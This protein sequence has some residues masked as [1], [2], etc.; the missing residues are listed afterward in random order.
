MDELIND[1]INFILNK[2][3]NDYKS[4]FQLLSI[5]FKRIKDNPNNKESY[6]IKISNSIFKEKTEKI[7]EI[8]SLIEL[9]GYC[10]S[11][12]DKNIYI[13]EKDCIENVNIANTILMNILSKSNP[14]NNPNPSFTNNN[15][16]NNYSNNLTSGEKVIIYQYDLTMGL[17]SSFGSALIGK[18]IEGVWHTAVVCFGKEYFYG[19]GIQVGTPKQTPYGKPV[20]ELD[21]GYTNKT[22]KE[23]SDFIKTINNKYCM[24]TYDLLYNNCN[25]FTDAAAYFLT[26]R[27]LPDSILKQHEELLNT[28]LG[29][30]IRPY[31]EMMRGQNNAFLPNMFENN[32]N[33]NGFG[34]NNNNFGGNNNGGGYFY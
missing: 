10:Q 21:F 17:A 23:F 9:I 22:E 32:N 16:N 25:H 12:E 19:G 31:L 13:I 24:Q 11:K 7:P 33:N 26:G 20:K 30:M 3:P 27:H 28:P 8:I 29:N 14:K 6:Q 15:N 1:S 18:Q 4:I 2:Y 5:F 34:G